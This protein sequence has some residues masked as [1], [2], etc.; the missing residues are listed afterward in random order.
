MKPDSQAASEQ[1]EKAFDGK[2]AVVTGGAQGIGRCCAESFRREGATVHVID[3]RPGPWFVGDL[4]DKSVLERFAAE[5]I[6]ASGR[7]DV[8]VNNAMPLFKGVDECSYEEF[9]YA[10][11]VGVVAPFYLAKLFKDHFAE[12]ASIVNISS[13]RGCKTD[14]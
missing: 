10:Q 4:A 14:S 12:G 7:V 8:L 13:S 2:V 5:V 9:A 3:V 1:G 11:A 6:T